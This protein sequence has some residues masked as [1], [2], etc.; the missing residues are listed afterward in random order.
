MTSLNQIIDGSEHASRLRTDLPFFAEHALKLRPKAGPLA[1]FILNPAQRKLHQLIEE[2]RAKIGRVRVIILKARQLGVSTYV[3]ARL[4]QKTIHNPGLRTIIIGHERRASSNLFQIVRRFHDH[5]PEDI[6]P[7]I[8]TSNAEELLFDRLDSGYIVSVATTEGTGRSATAQMLHCSETA[9]W[10]ELPLQMASLMQVCPDL[11]GTEII[12]ESTA[13]GYNDFHKMWRQAEAGESE[14]QPIFL[15]WSL[16]AAYRKEVGPDFTM[17]VEESKLAE[18]YGLDKEQ[19]AWR[20]S[21]ISQLGNADYFCQEY[22]LNAAE[23]LI[24]SQFDS[25]ISPALVIRARKEKAEAYGPTVIGVDPAGMGPDRS[26]IAWRQGRVITKI[27][28][29]KGLDTMEVAG[30]V[31]KIIREEKVA[32][33]NIDVGGLG[34]GVYDRLYETPSNRRIISAINFGG[35]CLEPAPLG[36]DGKPAGGPSNRRAEMWLALK[37]ALEGGRFV[38]PDRDSLQADL[39]STGYKFNSAGQLVL[40]SKQDMRRRGLPSPDEADAVALCFAD[41]SGF[42]RNADFHRNLKERYQ[43]AYA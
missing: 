6:R 39:V 1:P 24:S 31:Q 18:L 16:D 19:I 43:D 42:P 4:Y 15:P 33:A 26:A 35:K 14:F 32:R 5:M 25:F 30:W 2:Q 11:N 29:R 34:A 38:L 37:K 13:N 17:D 20:R 41:P 36:E 7:S 21:K 8:G 40:E 23:A 3:A 28:T 27:E 10:T 22:P 12:I 9:F